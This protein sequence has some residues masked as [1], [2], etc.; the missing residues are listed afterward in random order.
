MSSSVSILCPCVRCQELKNGHR[1]TLKSHL[2]TPTPPTRK[3]FLVSNERY[4]QK[5]T[6]LLRYYGTN[7]ASIKRY[8]QFCLFTVVYKEAQIHPLLTLFILFSCYS[9]CSHCLSS[10]PSLCPLSACSLFSLSTLSLSLLSLCLLSLF[11]CFFLYILSP[12]FSF[13]FLCPLSLSL[14]LY[15]IIELSPSSLLYLC[16]PSFYLPHVLVFYFFH[17]NNHVGR[18]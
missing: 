1:L 13:S 16:S 14:F 5:N 11:F 3:L 6:F 17:K 18:Q 4:G 10:S 15:S 9:F 8:D 12:L 2:P 7:F